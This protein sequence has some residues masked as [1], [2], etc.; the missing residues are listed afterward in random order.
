VEGIQAKLHKYVINFNV[1]LMKYLGLYGIQ[2]FHDQ[3]L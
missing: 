1:I 3:Y 2:K